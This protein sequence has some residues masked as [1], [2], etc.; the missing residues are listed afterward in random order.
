MGAQYINGAENPIYKIAKSLGVIDEVVSDAAH[1]DNAEYL[2]G[3]QPVD[4]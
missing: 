2:I 4:R 3:D 1:L